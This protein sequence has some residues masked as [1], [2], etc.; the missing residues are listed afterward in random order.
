[1][2]TSLA[3]DARGFAR[4]AS[5]CLALSLSLMSACAHQTT[6]VSEPP[7]AEVFIDGAHRGETPLVVESRSG[8][9]DL[10][11][12]EVRDPKSGDSMRFDVVHDAW[13]TEAIVL[14][15]LVG[16]GTFLSAGLMIVPFFIGYASL[17]GGVFFSITPGVDPMVALAV[18]LGA[19]ALTYGSYVAGILLAAS[20]PT[21]ALFIVGEGSRVGP[22]EVFIDFAEGDV[23]TSPPD[24][25]VPL[26]GATGKKQA[27]PIVGHE[28]RARPDVKVEPRAGVNGRQTTEHR[29]TGMQPDDNA[30]PPGAT[31]DDNADAFAPDER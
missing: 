29:S 21:V 11:R 18:I 4:G 6:F 26:A 24:L 9:P 10:E 1:M 8:A 22:D 13:H 16:V 28:S 2:T 30:Q 7:G 3:V 23:S 27:S 20:A 14:A 25:T 19:F 15:V 17:Y 5:L 31:S 12:V